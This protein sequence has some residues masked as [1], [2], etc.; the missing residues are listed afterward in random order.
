M[1]FSAL[2]TTSAKIRKINIFPKGLNHGFAS[3]MA[4]F[5]TFFL[6]S[7]DQ[8]NVFC[9]ILERKTAFLGYENKKFKESK[10]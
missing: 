8:E 6:A 1:P 2:K 7:I 5:Q 3:K 10:N 9:D 4:I